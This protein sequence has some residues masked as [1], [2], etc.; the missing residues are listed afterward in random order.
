MY[1]ISPAQAATMMQGGGPQT[2]Q[3][4]P[5]LGGGWGSGT[6]NG[7]MP[8]AVQR[9]MNSLTPR[10]GPQSM[11]GNP[12]DMPSPD[13]TPMEADIN[14]H[15][16]GDNPPVTPFAVPPAAKPPMNNFG[17]PPPPNGPGPGNVGTVPLASNVG[18]PMRPVTPTPDTAY[19]PAAGFNQPARPV[20]PTPPGLGFAADQPARPVTPTPATAA[21]P[22]PGPLAGGGAGGQ[23][24][25]SNPRFIGIDYRPNAD[26][27]AR[28]DPRGSLQGTALNLAGLFGGGGQN[29][30]APAANAQPVSGPLA[31]GRAPGGRY[32]NPQPPGGPPDYGMAPI[33]ITGYPVAGVNATRSP[34]MT[35]DQL[36]RAVRKP[37]WW[38]NV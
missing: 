24:S 30:N 18:P 16:T 22:V 34:D 14:G 28:T 35:P 11:S 9:M 10:L 4:L 27:T 2:A 21:A 7:Y 13:A 3:G 29:P 1:G 37:N 20:T 31:K 12:A 15:G 26:P 23:G 33:D 19:P 6:N 5:D 25:T 36:V 8:P 17:N 32:I 38:R